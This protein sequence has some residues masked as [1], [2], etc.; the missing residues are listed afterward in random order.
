MTKHPNNPDFL[1]PEPTASELL[2]TLHVPGQTI[3]VLASRVEKVLA[4]KKETPRPDGGEV[5]WSK[6]WNKAL[7]TVWRLLD[8]E[9]E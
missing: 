4:L 1:Y 2:D 6:G 9:G 8:G 5:Q 3:H 7:D